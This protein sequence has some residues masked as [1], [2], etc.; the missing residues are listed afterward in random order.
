MRGHQECTG[1]V[2]SFISREGLIP[3]SHPLSQAR[4]L[5]DQLLYRLNPA[6]CKINPDG[7]RLPIPLGAAT[8]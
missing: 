1:P 5:A 4:R 3:A 7:G 8:S 6:F 2:F